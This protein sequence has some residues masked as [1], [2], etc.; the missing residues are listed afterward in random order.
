MRIS[1]NFRSLA[2]GLAA[3]LLLAGAASAAEVRVMISGGLT[4]GLSTRWC[5][6]SSAPP[7]TRC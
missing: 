5:R 1:A 7:A 4:R 3:A 2:L 6:N